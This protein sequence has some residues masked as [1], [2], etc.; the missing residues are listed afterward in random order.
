K[1]KSKNP[2]FLLD[3]IDKMGMDWRG[4]PSAA[5][6]EVLDPEQNHAFLDHFLDVEFDLSEVFFI[7]TANTLFSIPPSL[8][9]RLEVIR[10]A[11]YT[12]EEKLHIARKY[13]IPK[14]TKDHG[15]PAADLQI[16][17]DAIR[18]I[19]REYTREA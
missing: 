12:E 19:I 15:I 5:L 10:F 8:Q 17:V 1:A 7:C 9:D 4:D 6:L 18:T 3:E 16:A 11:G 2:V 14:Q 13:L